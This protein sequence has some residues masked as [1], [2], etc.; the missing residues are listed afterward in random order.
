VGSLVSGLGSLFNGII[1]TFGGISPER[2]REIDKTYE[3]QNKKIEEVFSREIQMREENLSHLNKQL[4]A[5]TKAFESGQMTAEEYYKASGAIGGEIQK[6]QLESAKASKLQ[7]LMS[8]E[9]T[10]K[11]AVDE[12]KSK[13][14]PDQKKLNLLQKEIQELKNRQ[15]VVQNARSLTEVNMARH[16]A[17]QRVDRPTLFMA[18][19]AG[20]E[21]VAIK[22]LKATIDPAL[23]S[24]GGQGGMEQ[25][26]NIQISGFVGNEAQ[27][28]AE[29]VKVIQSAIRVSGEK[30]FRR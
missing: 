16:G 8:E 30:E 24:L 18:G 14:F 12:E 3:E 1:D 13:W 21:L 10:K 25:I 22:P 9:L 26:F 29:L 23:A 28:G 27:L 20:A 4:S 7:K 17:L 6:E 11:K 2:Q 15:T 19:E 5:F